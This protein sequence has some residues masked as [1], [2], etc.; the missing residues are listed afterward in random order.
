MESIVVEMNF[1]FVGVGR[2]DFYMKDWG[3]EVLEL[4]VYINGVIFLNLF[5]YGLY[6][7]EK[8][9]NVMRCYS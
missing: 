5:Y 9:I 4:L 8:L 2:D 1:N 6:M 3:E 7:V